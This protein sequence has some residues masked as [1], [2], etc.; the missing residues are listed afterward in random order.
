MFDY[1]RLRGKIREK[2]ITQAAFANS[3]G[4]STTTVSDKLN[5]KK[6]W[7]QKEIDSATELLEIPKKEISTYF[8][9]PGVQLIEHKIAPV[10]E[11][12]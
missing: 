4:V 11:I 10:S 5:N 1:S 7:S 9:T 8:F 3:I 12:Q 2:F 6:Q